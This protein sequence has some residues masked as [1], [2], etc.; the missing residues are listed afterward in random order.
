MIDESNWSASDDKSTDGCLDE[1]LRGNG[2]DNR[3]YGKY[4]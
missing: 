4:I 3:L 1:V 2:K